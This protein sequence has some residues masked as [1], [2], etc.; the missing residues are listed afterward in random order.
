VDTALKNNLGGANAK[1]PRMVQSVPVSFNGPQ[2]CSPVSTF[3]WMAYL[4][5][6]RKATTCN[7]LKMTSQD[8]NASI[9]TS[10]AREDCYKIGNPPKRPDK[11]KRTKSA[12]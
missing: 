12:S 11:R 6:H 3:R 10:V 7:P 9:Q 1:G 5:M 2:T 8:K 4:A